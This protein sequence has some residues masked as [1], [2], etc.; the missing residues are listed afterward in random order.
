[1]AEAESTKGAEGKDLS[2]FFDPKSVAVVGASNRPGSWGYRIALGII[3]GGYSG[4]LY[5]INRNAEAVLGRRSYRGLTEV[6]GDVEVV[7]IAIPA[8]RIWNVLRECPGKKVEGIIIV[9]SGFGEALGE[10]GKKLE[11]EIASFCRMHGIRVVGP[12][13]S[14]IYNMHARFCAAGEVLPSATPSKITFLCQG[15]YAVHNVVARARSKGVALGKFVQTGNEA[16]LQ[17]TD[18]LQLLGSDP[19]SEVILMYIEGLKEPRRFLKVAQNV[20][21]KKP[22]IVYKGGKSEAG[23]R[24]AESHTG[25][26]AGSFAI[27]KGFFKQAGCILVQ[28][29]ETILEIGHAFTFYPPLK[30]SRVGIVTQGGSWG[31]MLT[32]HIYQKGFIVPEFSS[33]LQRKLR[34]FGLPYRAS[35]R[36]PVD[37]GAAGLSLSKKARLSI[38]DALLS[39]AEIDALVFHGYG[40]RGLEPDMVPE[41]VSERQKDEEEVLRGSEEM[42]RA[43][44]KPVIFGCHLSRFESAT[45]R[46]LA[47]DGIPVFSRLEDISDVLQCLKLYYQSSTESS[48]G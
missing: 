10:E 33:S 5:L 20:A 44:E 12:N 39:S 16:D 37:F 41:W 29:F 27:H 11:K 13:V 4:E 18:F 17:C 6:P 43:Y 36:N 2:F 1:M 34:D 31:V 9:A 15:G 48:S 28:N 3:E 47:R 42:M 21:A 30:G 25:A 8:E 14:G 38:V 35:T 23:V 45:I 40:L 7:I 19:E 24:A 46:N 22:I 26:M 32:D